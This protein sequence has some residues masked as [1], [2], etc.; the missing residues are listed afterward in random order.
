MNIRVLI[1]ACLAFALLP[2]CAPEQPVQQQ[3]QEQQ[4][5]EVL[6]PTAPDASGLQPLSAG[7]TLR[8]QA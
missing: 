4:P 5:S 2:A 6:Q 3:A 1:S 8:L 7:S